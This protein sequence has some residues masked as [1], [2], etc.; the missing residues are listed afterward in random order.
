MDMEKVK[1]LNQI[2]NLKMI[3]EN[4]TNDKTIDICICTEALINLEKMIG[5]EADTLTF[6]EFTRRFNLTMEE[7]QGLIKV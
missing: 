3:E 1:E 7:L 2:Y 6:G 5:S 4:Y